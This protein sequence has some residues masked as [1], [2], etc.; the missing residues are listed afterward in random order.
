MLITAASNGCSTGTSNPRTLHFAHPLP[1]STPHFAYPRL[2]TPDP[3]AI[4]T[5]CY[6]HGTTVAYNWLYITSLVSDIRYVRRPSLQSETNFINDSKGTDPHRSRMCVYL[7]RP[8]PDC[9]CTRLTS[10]NVP[11]I[12]SYCAGEHTSCPIYRSRAGKSEPAP[13][14]TQ[15][16]IS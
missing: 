2:I 3:F 1:L 13:T 11:R 10:M 6:A 14:C 16:N 9:F 8:F 5:T 12:L 4:I 7:S 15:H